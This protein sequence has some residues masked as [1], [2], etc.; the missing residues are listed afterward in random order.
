MHCN[1][2]QHPRQPLSQF[3]NRRVVR[4]Q[5]ITHASLHS[6]SGISHLLVEIIR[7]TAAFERGQGFVAFH[8]YRM[9]MWSAIVFKGKY[10]PQRRQRGTTH[11]Y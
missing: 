2:L 5:H 11:E 4:S 1:V 7:E 9:D 8:T 3:F 6:A 10:M